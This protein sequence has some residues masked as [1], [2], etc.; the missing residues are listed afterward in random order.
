[1][2]TEIATD[3]L[4][5][6][7][8]AAYAIFKKTKDFG[9]L[10]GLRA[11]CCLLVIK[12]H[13]GWN[14]GP[15]IL[16]EAGFGVEVFFCIS[17]FLIVTLLIRERERTGD[18]GLKSF[19]ARRSLRIMPIYYTSILLVFVASLV[20]LAMHK[21]N[22]FYYYRWGLLVLVTYTQDIIFV[23][24]GSFHP[25]WSLA[26]EEQFYLAWPT[27][28]KYFPSKARWASLALLV[29]VSELVNFGVLR[30]AINGFYHN[31]RASIEPLFIITFAPIAFGV[32]LAHW[33]NEERSFG[34]AYRIM[35][36]RWSPVLWTVLLAIFFAVAPAD[37]SGLP[38]LITHILIALLLGS[39]V[40]RE[41]HVAAPLLKI[42]W[43]ARIGAI[44]YGLYLY[45]AWFL[46]FTYK[47][48]DRMAVVLHL[49]AFIDVLRFVVVTVLTLIVA[50]LS[51]R[52]FEQPI[53]RLRS[54]FQR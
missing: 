14:A 20:L 30:S 16:N 52:Y 21:P 28:E 36:H 1:V 17:G 46:G 12:E 27:I 37:L 5:K 33:F 51:F 7:T 19:Y 13:C 8:A 10:N 48:V 41:D 50:E 18:I 26:V 45:H 24:T 47:L 44:S 9:S 11:L 42:P 25:A 35:G 2:T 53:L 4:S 32:C 23:H 49:P 6:S 15:R 39:L 22:L 40:I 3:R 38:K 43:L 29:F 54:R 31:P 34:I